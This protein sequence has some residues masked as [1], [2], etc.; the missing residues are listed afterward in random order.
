MKH[1]RFGVVGIGN[2]GSMHAR[3]LYEGRIKNAVLGALCDI[4]EEKLFRAAERYGA[5]AY[6]DW[7]KLLHS[8]TVDAVIIAVPHYLHCEIAIAAMRA[9]LHV[10][11]EKPAG[12]RASDVRRMNE[13]A[14][15]HSTVFGIM[16][17]QRTE[18]IFQKARE[19]VHAGMLGKRKRLTWIITNWY[20]TQSYYDSGSWR[21]TW[22]GEGGGVLLNQ[23]PHNLDL[24]QWIF[25]MPKTVR[26]VCREGQ[27][28]NVTVEDYAAIY[29][30]YEDGA[31]MQFI[32]TTGE[33]P[34][35][36]RLE[37]VGDRGKMVL[38]EGK[39]KL[40]RLSESE[41]TVRFS[42]KEGMP[43]IPY[44]Y[45][46]YIPN[47][48]GRAHCGI[49]ENFTSAILNGTPLLADGREGIHQITLTNAAYLSSWTKGEVTLPLDEGLFDQL[50]QEKRKGE[51]EKKPTDTA[52]GGDE[53][54][55]PRWQVN[56]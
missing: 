18:P 49:L 46:E 21:A 6:S 1:V 7:Q 16:F 48:E 12:V 22:R 9:G 52:S 25:G 51:E 41:E 28:H 36:N 13:E 31:S 26:A 4:D 54:H 11:T 8:G 23:A 34:G 43:H 37:I 2:I 39:I 3:N 33:F 24:L 29:G 32:T 47:E 40:W 55:L 15:R 17:N 42:S 53:A 38:E 19:L 5:H 14:D 45:E 35:T 50:H 44:T 10:L 56:W 27:Y 30:E 20:R